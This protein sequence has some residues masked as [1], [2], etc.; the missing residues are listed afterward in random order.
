MIYFK[1]IIGC[2]VILVGFFLLLED[3]DDF[4]VLVKKKMRIQDEELVYRRTILIN[5]IY[6]VVLTLFVIANITSFTT[7]YPGFIFF[8][9]LFILVTAP[10]LLIYNYIVVAKKLK[11]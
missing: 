8:T 10:F 11:I 6:Y 3:F 7:K 5:T 1:I 4:A 9:F 2:I